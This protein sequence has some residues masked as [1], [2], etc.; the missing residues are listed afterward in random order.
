M[1]SVI[2]PNKKKAVT[3]LPAAKL[4]MLAAGFTE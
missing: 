4:V 1:Q 2:L 3:D